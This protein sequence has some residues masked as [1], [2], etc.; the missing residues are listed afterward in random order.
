MSKDTPS[1]CLGLKGDFFAEVLHQLRKEIRYA[2]YVK[3]NLRLF[4][5]DDLRDHK[6]ISRLA[7]AFLKVL[8]PD[9]KITDNEFREYC[10]KPAVELRQR[11]RDELYKLDAEYPK[12]SIEIS[13]I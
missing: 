7:T 3:M 11:V 8:F 5:S 12:V 1:N 9:L 4:G 6:A 10:V 13:N 2:D